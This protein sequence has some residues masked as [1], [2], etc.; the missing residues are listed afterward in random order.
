M[1]SAVWEGIGLL[2]RLIALNREIFI[3]HIRFRLLTLWQEVFVFRR[4][5]AKR[6]ALRSGGGVDGCRS[7]W[8]QHEDDGSGRC[9]TVDGIKG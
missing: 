1:R 4:A 6:C 2:P 7:A 8:V 9:Y 5:L 3:R